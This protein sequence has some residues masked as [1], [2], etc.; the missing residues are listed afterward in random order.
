M[1]IGGFE[2]LWACLP[3]CTHRFLSQKSSASASRQLE[4][5]CNS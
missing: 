2:D 1:C 5:C 4:P 3:F